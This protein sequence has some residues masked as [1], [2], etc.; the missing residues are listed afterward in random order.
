MSNREPWLAVNF[1]KIL[2][3]LGQI[4]SGDRNRG[5]IIIAL[6]LLLFIISFWLILGIRGSIV[7]GLILLLSQFVLA[8]WNLFDAYHCAKSKNSPEFESI[9]K[10]SKDP[11]LGTF[12]SNLFLGIGYFYIGKWLLGILAIILII[13][14]ASISLFLLPIVYAVISYFTYVF[15]PVHRENSKNM[16]LIL[17]IFIAISGLLNIGW[18]IRTYGVEARWIPS[19][20][21][22]PTL[23]GTPNQWEADKILVDKFSY[24]FQTP[25]RGDIIVFWPTDELLKEQY[26]DAFIKR[27]VGLPGEKVELKN[28]QV[29]INNQVLVEDRYLP[30]NQRTLIDVC[31]PGTPYLVKPVTIPSESYLV[32]GDNRNSSYDSR[33]WGVVSRNLIIGKAYKRFYP[34][35]RVGAIK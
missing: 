32:L 28:G 9:R 24:R 3:G 15:S 34:L 20:A 18:I 12:L 19:G 29:Y 2:P 21:M 14:C 26:Q 4:Y 25:Q 10:A 1:S 8:I 11:W 22:E 17:A 6:Y 13:I 35:N 7:L 27:I 30:A 33:C 31:T 16:A 5:Y 23:H